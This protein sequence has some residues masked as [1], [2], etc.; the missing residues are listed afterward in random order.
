MGE[1]ASGELGDA[2]GRGEGDDSSDP[3]AFGSGMEYG[4]KGA[5]ARMQSIDSA[6]IDVNRAFRDEE[7]RGSLRQLCPGRQGEGDVEHRLA[8]GPFEDGGCDA[9]F[10]FGADG[11]GLGQGLARS[12]ALDEGCMRNGEGLRAE[13]VAACNDERKVFEFGA[14]SEFCMKGQ[15]GDE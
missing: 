4:S 8:G 2:T 3:G 10:D 13:A 6:G 1:M 11:P 14:R 9:D 7:A 15:V 12:N 5:L